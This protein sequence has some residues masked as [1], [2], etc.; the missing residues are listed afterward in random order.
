MPKAKKHFSGLTNINKQSANTNLKPRHVRTKKKPQLIRSCIA[1]EANS[2]LVQIACEIFAEKKELAIYVNRARTLCQPPKTAAQLIAS[3]A[4]RAK[5]LKNTTVKIEEKCQYF[6]SNSNGDVF[7][8]N[9]ETADEFTE[10]TKEKFPN[11]KFSYLYA[12][13][14]KE[15]D[16]ELMPLDSMSVFVPDSKRIAVAVKIRAFVAQL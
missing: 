9:Q 13:V 7:Y 12:L 14:D 1:P 15:K 10:L 4:L 11:L 2:P 16:I 6:F 8:I 5:C 3:R